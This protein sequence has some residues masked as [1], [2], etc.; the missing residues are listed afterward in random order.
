MRHV[1]GFALFLATAAPLWC[2]SKPHVVFLG[3]PQ[4]VRMFSGRE[5][6]QSMTINVRPLYVD[7]KLK[8][9]TTGDAHDVTDRQFV[10][11]RAFRMND[12]LPGDSSRQSKWIWERGDWLLVDR[13]SGHI[14]QVRL[15]EFDSI[16]SRVSW[17]R[18]YAAYCSISD[19]GVRWSATVAQ[20]GVRKA[21]FH[22]DL[23]KSAESE[24][25]ASASQCSSPKW[26]RRP[27]RVTFLPTNG[28][29]LTVN[30]TARRAQELVPE[31][32]G[33]Q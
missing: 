17:Y 3:K 10:V 33:E 26:E 20:I 2:A 7:T 22:K 31:S 8:E 19:N 16:Y 30:V 12:S 5:E 1:L 11:Q 9:Y 4:P 25:D 6:N 32:E 28:Q 27:P 14:A 13:V 15:P 29:P 24:G 18:D 21:L 23:G